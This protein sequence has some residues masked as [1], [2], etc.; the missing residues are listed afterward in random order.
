M[1]K[2]TLASSDARSGVDLRVYTDVIEGAVHNIMPAA[3]VIV[4][5]SCYYVDPTPTQG[6][7]VRIGR[8]ICRSELAQYCIQIPK[9]FSSVEIKPVVEEVT[10]NGTKQ[11]LLGGHH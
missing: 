7:A 11:K 1:R 5:Q 10:E 6:D 2:Y 9:L 8:Q 3:S 4:E